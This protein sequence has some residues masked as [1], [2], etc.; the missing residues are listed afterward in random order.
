MVSIASVAIS[1][2]IFVRVT[3]SPLMRPISAPTA[4]LVMLASRTGTPKSLTKPTQS[5][6]DTASTAP[7]DRSM[8]ATRMTKDWPMAMTAMMVEENSRFSMLR[9]DRK[10]G[11]NTP[12]T[13]APIAM[14]ISSPRS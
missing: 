9:R 14:T 3:L 1:A 11:L 6:E 13:V 2:G 5:T 4:R 12:S 7:T 8:P 10:T